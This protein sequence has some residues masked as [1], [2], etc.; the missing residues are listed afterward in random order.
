MTPSD[1]RSEIKRMS[2]QAK[3]ALKNI[4]VKEQSQQI[5]REDLLDILKLPYWS[6]RHVLY[7]SWLLA[8]IEK[9]LSAY[10]S[11]V[12]HSDGVLELTFKATKVIEAKFRDSA[13]SLWAE[14][15][16]PV[17]NPTGK[18]RTNNIQPDYTL[19]IHSDNTESRCFSVIECK[20]YR[21]GN[22]RNFSQAIND[23]ANGHPD[24]QVFLVND[25]SIA[26]SLDRQIR[27]EYRAR[28][29]YW[30]GVRPGS[31]TTSDFIATL[32]ALCNNQIKISALPGK[33]D[34]IAIDISGSMKPHLADDVIKQQ[35]ITIGQSSPDAI[36]I[37]I[38][39]I[40]VNKWPNSSKESIEQLLDLGTL[41][42]NDLP[43]AIDGYNLQKALIITDN[44]GARQIR[45]A[46]LQPAE[47]LVLT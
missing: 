34:L 9:T 36:L 31:A 13:I 3:D 44:D 8:V 18:G 40:V 10:K 46:N 27:Q 21:R 11:Q 37:S 1:R 23:Y 35:I 24:A 5:N 25:G 47:M 15:K 16:T 14:L 22:T 29:R 17:S 43:L 12:L 33:F 42:F 30:A 2:E 32:N 19:H 41:G 6:K 45:S 20:Q 7:Q 4:P 38:N 28:S 39:T 26:R